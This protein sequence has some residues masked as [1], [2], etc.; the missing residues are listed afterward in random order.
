M[1]TKNKHVTGST[2]VHSIAKPRDG[3]V[4]RS[5]YI[6]HWMERRPR[7]GDIDRSNPY[8]L[9]SVHRLVYNVGEVDE[10]ATDGRE[11]D[12]ERLGDGY[13]TLPWM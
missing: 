6:R 2:K 1:I 7:D 3:T 12:R 10:K 9:I 5:K 4:R 8:H 13:R 11:G